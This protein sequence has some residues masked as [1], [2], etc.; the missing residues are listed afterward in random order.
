VSSRYAV[1]SRTLTAPRGDG[2][3]QPCRFGE[4]RGHWAAIVTKATWMQNAALTRRSHPEGTGAQRRNDEV[5]G[6]ML[7]IRLGLTAVRRRG[8][9]TRCR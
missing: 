6:R 1:A 7:R 3:W 8:R 2:C 5:G 9:L 4:R